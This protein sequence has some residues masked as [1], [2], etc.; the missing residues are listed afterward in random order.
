VL[1]QIAGR[2]TTRDITS[3]F[4]YDVQP[5]EQTNFHFFVRG[6]W[7]WTWYNVG[8]VTID[9]ES[10]DYTA[11]GGYP[12]SIFPSRRWW[13]NTWYT[14][15][16]VEYFAPRRSWILSQV[17]YGLRAEFGTSSHRLGAQNPGD[18]AIGT[19]K[20]SDFSLAAVVG[21]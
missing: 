7:G 14:G 13:P 11:R 20:R 12:V 3:G 16:G 17:G 21:W 1:S 6:G 10:D 5:S 8:G 2:I 18:K 15:G 19:A 4:R 9:G